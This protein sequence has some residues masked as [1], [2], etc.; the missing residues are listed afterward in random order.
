MKEKTTDQTLAEL[1]ALKTHLEEFKRAEAKS[2]EAELA[3][4]ESEEKFSILFNNAGDAIFIHDMEGRF[5]EVNQVACQ[6]LGYHKDELLKMTPMDIDSPQ[7][8]AL[9]PMRI[10]ELRRRSHIIFESAHVRR[11]G[12]IIPIEIS[13]RS[14]EYEGKPAV[15]SIARDITDRKLAEKRIR[16]SEEKYRNLVELTT[17]II[18]LSDKDG[19]QIFMNEAGYSLLEATTDEVIGKP[20]SKWIHPDDVERSFKKFSEMIEKGVDVFEFENRYLS[21]NGK[22]TN[23]IHNVRVLRDESGSIVGTQGIARD[24]TERK[25]VEESLRLFSGAVEEAP[26]GVQIT[27]LE[28]RIIYSNKAVEEIYGFS[29]EEF[30][31][32][33]VNEMNEDPEFAGKVILPGIIN[34]GRWTGEIM[35]KHKDG[36]VFPIWLTTSMVRDSKGKPIALMGIIKDITER[37][38]IEQVLLESEER[39]RSLFENSPISLWEEDSTDL[40]K[41]VDALKSKGIKDLR[42]YFDKHPKEIKLIASMVKVVDVNKT[43]IELFKAKSKGDL[44]DSLEKIFTERS[45]DLFKEE[46]IA[47]AEGKTSFEIEDIVK[48]LTGDEIHI[49]LRWVLTPGNEETYSKRLV[50]IIDITERKHAEEEIKKYARELL[51]SNRMKE[52]FTDIMHH[53]LLNPL[54]IAKGYA[55]LLHEAETDSR[56][57][58]YIEAIERNVNKGITLIDSTTMLSKLESMESI[59]F[60]DLDIREI[61]E[62]VIENL[63]PMASEAGMKIESNITGSMPARANK[64]IEEVFSNLIS[65]AVKYASGGKK[66]II[67]GEDAGEFWRIKVV[68]FGEGIDDAYKTVVFERFRRMEKLGVK[69]SGLGLA[70]AGKIVELHKGRIWVE[71]NPE[72]GAVF[73]VEIPKS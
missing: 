34:S 39:Y 21:K 43:T 30:K 3:L 13:S 53:D 27:D 29:R 72:G 32:K 58:A 38:R 8:A 68:D 51:E 55:E 60:E 59:G 19:N 15:L 5:L 54:S 16:E 37:R 66:I 24:V 45:Y 33:H 2:K 57:L 65:N 1:D 6:R 20:W 70:I 71:D 25:R 49:S 22:I 17:D 63:T 42:A 50:S 52:L 69:G 35:V 40:K 47:I 44:R 9:V 41:Y 14:I 46:L 67:E 48:T 26:D 4:R 7:Y 23:V 10:E 18:Y 36:E 31:G 62:D 61:I 64:I 28:G 11:D 12:S 56:R 73:N